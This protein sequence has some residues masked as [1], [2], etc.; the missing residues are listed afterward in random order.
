LPHANP[1]PK[2]RG[3]KNAIIKVLSLGEDLGEATKK[4]CFSEQGFIII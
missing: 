4:P 3:K 2:E 1:S